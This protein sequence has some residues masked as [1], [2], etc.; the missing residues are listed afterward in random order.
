MAS[1]EW[2]SFRDRALSR[3]GVY[4]VTE[5]DLVEWYSLSPLKQSFLYHLNREEYRVALEERG[6]V[7]DAATARSTAELFFVHYAWDIGMLTLEEQEEMVTVVLMPRV[8]RYIHRRRVEHES[9][10]DSTFLSEVQGDGTMTKHVQ[11]RLAEHAL[12]S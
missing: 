6:G 10:F 7:I 8:L 3:L 12:T 9:L 11:R 4:H 2:T 1:G 5:E